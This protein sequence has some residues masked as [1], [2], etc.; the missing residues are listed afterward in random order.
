[1]ETW[2]WTSNLLCLICTIC[3]WFKLSWW[4]I[5]ALFTAVAQMSALY[6]RTYYMLLTKP[7]GLAS[8]SV[9]EISCKLALS[10][11][12]WTNGYN[13][14][15]TGCKAVLQGISAR[16][17]WT[18]NVCCQQN[19]SAILGQQTVESCDSYNQQV[20]YIQRQYIARSAFLIV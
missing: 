3:I 12:D 14:V 8:P 20:W 6:S 13:Y 15:E 18:S 7:T 11:C 1:M 4:N 9:S 2:N 16:K 10:Y 19:Q 17:S 5:G